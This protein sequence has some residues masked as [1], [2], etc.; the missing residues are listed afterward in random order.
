MDK[1]FAQQILE[2]TWRDYDAIA[3]LF[4]E[5]R[6]RVYDLEPLVSSVKSGD[7]VLDVGCGNG[8][9]LGALPVGVQY[10]GC[11]TSVQMIAIA[12]KRCAI[13]KGH[14]CKKQGCPLCVRFVLG[15]V[16]RLPFPDASFDHVFALAVLHHIPSTALR[17][18]AISELVRLV[19]PGGRITITVWNLRSFY[20][21]KRYRL[22]QL[23]FGL[24]PQGYDRGDCFVPWKRGVEKPIMRYVH[25][26][27]GWEL[28]K[29]CINGG[30][31]LIAQS[32]GRSHIVVATRP[33][34]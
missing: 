21:M 20:W 23:F 27:T 2:K 11:D 18:Q 32:H 12:K 29:L 8:R 6:E 33:V 28:A 30:L 26:F 22:W 17:Q 24:H 4:S 25:A 10:V 13:Y 19:K 5:T 15:D 14:L 31:S 9:L 3:S 7:T 34:V 1:K 16:L